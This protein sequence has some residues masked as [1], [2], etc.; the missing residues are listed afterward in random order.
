MDHPFRTRIDH[1]GL[2]AGRPR[3]LFDF[4]SESLGLPVTAAFTTTPE[5]A[6]GSVGLGNCFRE[7]SKGGA[8]PQRGTAALS[9]PTIARYQVL[10][11]Q[12]A[13]GALPDILPELERRGVAHS[14]VV[15][16]YAPGASEQAAV[17]LWD[18]VYLGDLLGGNVWQQMLCAAG[19]R[20]PALLRIATSLLLRA[21]PHGTPV[22]TAYYPAAAA[23]ADSRAALRRAQGGALGVLGARRGMVR[24]PEPG[25]WSR[26]LGPPE[27]AG[28]LAWQPG[29]GPALQVL[30][31]PRPGIALLTLQVADLGR[32][33]AAL[34]ALGIVPLR[35]DDGLA[36][37]VPQNPGL[38]MGLV[39]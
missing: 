32:A 21:F 36:F 10:S 17:R 37:T 15:P 39:E 18:S 19:V 6:G 23:Q 4:F 12:V 20:S 13:P 29:S 33:R 26:L 38:Q 34:V 31:D 3:S 11:L 2:Y 30:P 8:P 5:H 1:L 16:T 24:T 14:G 35:T 9:A 28:G 7:S 27:A 25:A 22:L